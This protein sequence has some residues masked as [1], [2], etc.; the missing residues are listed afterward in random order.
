MKHF[1][2]ISVLT[3]S[4]LFSSC[5]L[6]NKLTT[7]EANTPD[8]T[9]EASV[10]VPT[11]KKHK[12]HSKTSA[13]EVPEILVAPSMDV[14]T[15]GQWSI[16][17]VGQTE[18]N[19]EDD[20]P[21]IAFDSEGR[22]YAYDGCN[23]VNGDYTLRSDGK[24]VF[25]NSLSTMRYCPDAEFSTAI[26]AL[27]DERVVYSTDC[28]GENLDTYMYLK[29]GNGVVK[30]TL[31]RHNMEFLNGN[32]RVVSADG[33]KIKSEEA[34]IFI[35]VVELKIHGN[36]GCN[37]FNGEVYI[38]PVKTNAVDFSNMAMTRM[39][40]PNGD[41]ERAIMV[42]LESTVTAA[43]GKKADTVNFFDAKGKQ[44]MTLEKAP[45]EV[46]NQND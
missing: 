29:D 12:K 40:C 28:K 24:L 39:A 13:E 45:V 44:I 17:A 3:C 15:G 14:L 9:I 27:F 34:T 21:Y 35:D 6:Y 4:I 5:S 36:T 19:K 46:V 1:F 16:V 37:F 22:F 43:V 20:Q 38:D 42:A 2:S 30:A 41:Q 25:A 23:I 18:I 33:K 8:A 26:A 7:P 32:W 31:R 10:D 11:G